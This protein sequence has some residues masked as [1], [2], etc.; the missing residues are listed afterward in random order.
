MDALLSS[1][2]SNYL[3]RWFACQPHLLGPQAQTAIFVGP[4][5]LAAIFVR[6]I[7]SHCPWQLCLFGHQP[8]LLGS[9]LL[10]VLGQNGSGQ[11]GM[12]K[13]VLDQ[14]VWAKWYGQN[15]MAKILW[16]KSSINP[17][18]IWQQDFFINPTSTL[19][20]LAFPY[21]LIIYLWLLV[22]KYIFNSTELKVHKI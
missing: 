2:G 3:S 7:D 14:M 4:L 8:Y 13:M 22:T 6:P 18:L 1:F 16:I 10:T 12:D 21:M 9:Q 11:N 20:P 17:A 15:G 5:T 19:M